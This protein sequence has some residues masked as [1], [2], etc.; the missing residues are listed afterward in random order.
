MKRWLKAE[1]HS[2]TMEDPIDGRRIIFHSPHQLIDAAAERGF[3]VLSITNHNQLLFNSKLQDYAW[4]RGVLLI[5]GVESTLRGKHVL[6]YNFLN[7]DPSWRDFEVLRKNKGTEQLVIA[8]HP[9]F[10]TASSLWGQFFKNSDLFD[11]VEYNHF[12]LEWLNFNRRAA[13]AASKCKLPVVG[14]SDVHRLFQL[15]CTYSLIHAEKDL[16]SVLS[17]IKEGKV[18]LV[19]QPVSAYFVSR[20]FA[21]NAASRSQFAFRSFLGLY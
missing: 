20:W 6:L 16:N 17:G 5:P 11:A 14:N 10:P 21:F 13:R 3:E 4:E 15:G 9:F 8:P 2:H 19:T 7:Y 12:Y 18:Q 1:L